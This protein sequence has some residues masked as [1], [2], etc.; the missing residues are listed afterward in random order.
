MALSEECCGECCDAISQCFSVPFSF[1]AFITFFIAVI[2]FILM[3]VALVQSS[4]IDCEESFLKP[5][6]IVQAINN[7][8]NF[9]FSIYLTCHYGYKQSQAN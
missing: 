4:G 8:I 9:L 3:I 7:L 6:L 5:A 1:C 2:P